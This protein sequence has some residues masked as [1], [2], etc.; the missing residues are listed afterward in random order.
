MREGMV[1]IGGV[2]MKGNDVK[3]IDGKVFIDG[4]EVD[5]DLNQDKKTN[6]QATETTG[7]FRGLFRKLLP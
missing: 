3:I 2:T 7:F 1:T 4:V 6:S 5:I